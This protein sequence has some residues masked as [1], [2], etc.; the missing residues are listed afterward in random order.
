MH[1]ISALIVANFAMG[2]KWKLGLK[3]VGDTN[4][5]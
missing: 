1:G 4:L 5:K 2:A 3:N